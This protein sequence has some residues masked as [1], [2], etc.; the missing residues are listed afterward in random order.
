MSNHITEESPQSRG[1]NENFCAVGPFPR[2]GMPSVLFCTLKKRERR[3]LITKVSRNH[4]FFM[5]C[6]V[7]YLEGTVYTMR[8]SRVSLPAFASCEM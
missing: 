4:S 8:C 7:A 2:I 1:E 5:D 6:N 3:G